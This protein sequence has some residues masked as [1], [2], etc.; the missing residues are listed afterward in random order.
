LG[1][2]VEGRDALYCN[3]FRP[4]GHG[5]VTAHGVPEV[6]PTTEPRCTRNVKPGLVP[7]VREGAPLVAARP[8]PYVRIW[9]ELWQWAIVA[10]VLVVTAVVTGILSYRRGARTERERATHARKEREEK[11]RREWRD[12]GADAI[13]HATRDLDAVNQYQL[14]ELSHEEQV[15]AVASARKSWRGETSGEFMRLAAIHSDAEVVRATIDARAR[16][17]GALDATARA[18]ALRPLPPEGSSEGLREMFEALRA[19]ATKSEPLAFANEEHL[20]STWE[21]TW[22]RREEAFDAMER[23]RKALLDVVAEGN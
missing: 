5:A 22:A 17:D 20:R 18:V 7:L 6:L 8:L 1:S 10:A 2:Q 15:A 16:I 23:L 3:A 4:A 9:M 14:E 19:T 21:A 12:Q 13:T 11:Q